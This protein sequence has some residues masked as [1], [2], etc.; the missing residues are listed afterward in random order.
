MNLE[1]TDAKRYELE[2]DNVLN[3]ILAANRKGTNIDEE[4]LAQALN[5]DLATTN[6]LITK[7]KTDNI[8]K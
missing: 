7:L 1:F 5:I 3:I 4:G 6:K 2:L 8:I